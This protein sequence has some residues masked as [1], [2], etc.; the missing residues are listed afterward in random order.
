M[1]AQ[2]LLFV[3]LVLAACGQPQQQ[4]PA[5]AA[6]I[7][8][9]VQSTAPAGAYTTEKVHSS[10]I[11]R[12]SHLGY[13]QF[14]AR[15]T[16]WDAQLQFD[17]ANPERSQVN[18]TI[19]PR[20][21]ASDN[22]LP[23]FI[24]QMRGTQFLDAAQFP[25]IT[26]RSTRVER[27]G[28]NTA[29]ITGDLTLHGVTKPVT[30]EA[31]FNGGYEGMQL[32]PHARIG[33]SAHGAFKR[34]DFGMRFGIPAPGTNMGVGDDVSVIIETELTGPAWTAPPPTTP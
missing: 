2:L 19:D 11:V 28:P 5:S 24:D 32:D 12:L 33:F 1:K 23:G 31:R 21:I 14:T 25:N 7:E 26:F 17:P 13:S 16:T 34:S 4:A 20:S 15:F 22:P 9:Q 30:L 29:N 6:T 3:A 8:A 27:T 18:V 10:M